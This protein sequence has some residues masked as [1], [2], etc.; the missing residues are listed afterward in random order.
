M[1][2]ECVQQNNGA[3]LVPWNHA[4]DVVLLVNPAART[5]VTIWFTLALLA[6]LVAYSTLIDDNGPFM[7]WA[8]KQ[9]R[10]TE[11]ALI[12]PTMEKLA[13]DGQRDAVIW[14]ARNGKLD[15][16]RERLTAL[17]ATGDGEAL[18]IAAADILESDPAEAERLARQSAAAGYFLAVKWDLKVPRR[19][20][21]RWE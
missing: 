2:T 4:R 6:W 17:V 18:Y 15:A 7:Q 10:E 9:D 5:R 12:T 21:T 13:A 8:R 16:V 1:N 3:G 20:V 19:Q 11:R 14:L